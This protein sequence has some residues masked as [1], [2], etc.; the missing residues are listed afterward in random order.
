MPPSIRLLLMWVAGICFT[1][2]APFILSLFTWWFVGVVFSTVTENT[3]E[4][5]AFS[6]WLIPAV[7]FGFAISS[8]LVEY[9]ASTRY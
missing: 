4:T 3:R 2:L 9:E 7:L 5:L 8:G 6:M 1:L